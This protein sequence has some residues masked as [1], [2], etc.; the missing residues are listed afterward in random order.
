MAAT[1]QL[2]DGDNAGE[3]FSRTGRLPDDITDVLR[4]GYKVFPLGRD[5]KKPSMSG[6]FYRGTDN[7]QKLAAQASSRRG[8]AWAIP[9]GQPS[10]MVAIESDNDEA[11]A[12]LERRLGRPADVKSKRGFHWYFGYEGDARL[13]NMIDMFKN[14]PDKPNGVDR[15]ADGGYVAIPP[16]PNKSWV[17][18]IP[19]RMS[20]PP[21][22]DEFAIESAGEQVNVSHDGGVNLEAAEAI[23]SEVPPSGRHELMLRLA[24]VMIRYGVTP[25]DAAATILAAWSQA[26]ALTSDARRDILAG[27]AD[28][29]KMLDT[30]ARR[31]YGAPSLEADFRGLFDALAASYGWGK[32]GTLR[33]GGKTPA[34]KADEA[35]GK[36]AKR[37]AA[38]RLYEYAR[39]RCEPFNDQYGDAYVLT[40]EGA[41]VSLR[42]ANPWLPRIMRETEGRVARREDLKAVAD[43]LAADADS[44]RH[45][46]TRYARHAGNVYVDLKA[47][48]VVEVTPRGW[49]EIPAADAPVLFRPNNVSLELPSPVRGG[50]LDDLAAYL[51]PCE[52]ASARLRAAWVVLAMLPDVSRPILETTGDPGAGK[53][54]DQGLIK[55]LIDPSVGDLLTLA[56]GTF[57]QNL[58]F[59]AVPIFDNLQRVD[60][61][62]S[63]DLCRAVTGAAFQRRALYTDE[64]QIVRSYKRAVAINGV[65]VPGERADLQ[66]RVLPI[67]LTRGGRRRTDAELHASFDEAWSVLL[68]AVLDALSAALRRFDPHAEPPAF[69]LADWALYAKGVY[70][71]AGWPHLAD[72]LAGVENMRSEA[73][74]DGSP[75]ARAIM[76]MIS[77]TLNFKE[78]KG[79]PA[80]LFTKCRDM[81][82]DLGDLAIF[83][84]GANTFSGRLGE[85]AHALE[86]RG[87]LVERVRVNGRRQV[88]ITRQGDD[89]GDGPGRGSSPKRPDRHQDRHPESRIP[90][91]NSSQGDDG[92]DTSGNLYGGSL[93]QVKEVEG[94]NTPDTPPVQAGKTTVT[95]VTQPAPEVVERIAEFYKNL[96]DLPDDVPTPD[97]GVDLD[98]LRAATEAL[99]AD[100]RVLYDADAD[101]AVWA[102]ELSTDESAVYA[103]IAEH[104]A[105]DYA[106]AGELTG[107]NGRKAYDV[108]QQLKA[109]GL[110]KFVG[111]GKFALADEAAV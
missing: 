19:N 20:L 7:P 46:H 72:D 11:S 75:V 86:E 99:I 30:D 8:C 93:L 28:T 110:V 47:G 90:A 102:G 16:S 65:A 53:S 41:V 33:I 43:A 73:V 104:G 101:T 4:A 103:A 48:R 68:G 62:T 79:E 42:S 76:R 88:R 64:D 32:N 91:R 26:G 31:V 77:T 92:D 66:D 58:L 34:E 14:D 94:T 55:R 61:D 15:K 25:A 59:H 70:E 69:R 111:E 3:G 85:A 6:G 96:A 67:K 21:L 18:G 57:L 78:W 12:W 10:E 95:T 24:G 50:S 22:P 56:R 84:R 109:R 17:N 2:P 36:D 81:A 39:A 89:T 37:S 49:A 54:T 108:Q 100:G 9:T 60:A 63:D 44:V 106:R 107:L 74:I 71:H 52:P 23:A 98:T 105:M 1:R 97:P 45:L 35:G 29:V 13:G 38:D 51:K 40:G 87:I 83:P 80:A 27:V 5:G 82:E